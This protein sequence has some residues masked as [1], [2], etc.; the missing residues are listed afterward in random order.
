MYRLRFSIILILLLSGCSN[1]KLVNN[2]FMLTDDLT[3][4]LLQPSS[5]GKELSLTQLVEYQYED[6]RRELLIQ[7]EITSEKMILVGLTT[8]GTRLFNILF[9]GDTITGEGYHLLS[10]NVQIQYML[11]DIQLA[12]WPIK[13]IHQHLTQTSDCYKMGNC[14]LIE[15]DDHLQRKLTSR[16]KDIF[17]IKYQ[18][19]PHYQS[20]ITF[21]NT[22]RNYSLTITLLAMEQL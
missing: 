10:N 5:F 13:K 15:S 19:I 8:S 2:Q 11:A 6:S 12:L 18:S 17:T 1:T 14:R 7:S 20:E 22:L 21:N 16:G 3:F 9:D 4:T